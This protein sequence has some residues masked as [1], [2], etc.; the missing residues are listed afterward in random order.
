MQGEGKEDFVGGDGLGIRN[1]KGNR[2]VEF[3]K[4]YK[5]CIM[6]TIFYKF[7]KRRLY[8]WSFPAESIDQ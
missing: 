4:E 8:T 6:N 5:H 3:C 1:E 2:F 7:P